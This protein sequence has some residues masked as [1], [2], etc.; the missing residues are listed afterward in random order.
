[1]I[2]SANY[3]IYYPDLAPLFPP[4][5]DMDEMRLVVRPPVMMYTPSVYE[6]ATLIL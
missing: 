2:N 3:K 1:M 4:E 5:S 6:N